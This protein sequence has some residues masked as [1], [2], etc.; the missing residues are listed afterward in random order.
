MRLPDRALL[1]FP[2]IRSHTP[3][4]IALL[5]CVGIFVALYFAAVSTYWNISPDSATYVGFAKAFA[6]GTLPDEPP[7]QP[8]MTSLLYTP[9]LV[10]FPDSYL[11]AQ[12]ADPCS[13]ARGARLLLRAARTAQWIASRA[14]RRAAHAG[15]RIGLPREHTTALRARL[16]GVL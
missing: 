11:C 1:P 13:P 3:V 16:H 7:L 4:V 6:A 12:R 5:V 14:A 9:L 2:Q 15:F 10:L 8:P